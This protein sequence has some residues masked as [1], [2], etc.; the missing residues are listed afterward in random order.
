MRSS[1]VEATTPKFFSTSKVK[2]PGIS[3]NCDICKFFSNFLTPLKN[4]SLKSEFLIS[5]EKTDFANL[6]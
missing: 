4:Y 1:Q 2:T 3:R 5:V 6:P